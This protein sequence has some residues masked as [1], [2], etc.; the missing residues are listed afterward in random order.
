MRFRSLVGMGILSSWAVVTVAHA[1]PRFTLGN[2][3]SY[4]QGT[5]GTG[6]HINIFYDATYF[7]FRNR[8]SLLEC[9]RLEHGRGSAFCRLD[10]PT[11]DTGQTSP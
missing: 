6:S 8:D 1:A 2:V 9:D 5:F 7:Q 11:P 4:Y 3:P 10:G